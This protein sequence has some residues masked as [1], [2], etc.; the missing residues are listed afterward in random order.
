MPCENCGDRSINRFCKFCDKLYFKEKPKII[1][2][3]SKEKSKKI[4][5]TI[6]ER[7][8]DGCKKNFK[9]TR[10]FRKYCCIECRPKELTPAEK[11]LNAKP[12][13]NVMHCD[14]VGYGFF[15]KKYSVSNRFNACRG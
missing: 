2:R 8:C 13:V 3:K 7:I 15:R 9:Q 12:R 11:W 14:R 6:S 4:I 5:E 10:K 1:E